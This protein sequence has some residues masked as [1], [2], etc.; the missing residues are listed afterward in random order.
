MAEAPVGI[1]PTP[2]GTPPSTLTADGTIERPR[3]PL[4]GMVSM[5]L[6][7]GTMNPSTPPDQKR[8]RIRGAVPDE[9]I[10]GDGYPDVRRCRHFLFHDALLL[11]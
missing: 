10:D 7:E 1:E 3:T 8:A 2:C 11:C 9:F 6:T 5:A 4:N